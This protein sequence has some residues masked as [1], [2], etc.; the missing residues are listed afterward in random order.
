MTCSAAVYFLGIGAVYPGWPG[1]LPDRRTDQSAALD[2]VTAAG[3]PVD[4][5][6]VDV[7][8]VVASPPKRTRMSVLRFRFISLLMPAVA[9]LPSA[10]ACVWVIFLLATALFRRAVT[11][12]MTALSTACV[13]DPSICASVSP[14]RRSFSTVVRLR[15]VSLT[16]SRKSARAMCR[17]A[18][19]F[20][21]EW[22]VLAVLG[23]GVAA[24]V[25][26]LPPVTPA[27]RA[28]MM[29]TVAIPATATTAKAA[30]LIATL[31]VKK[32]PNILALLWFRLVL[33][34]AVSSF[35]PAVARVP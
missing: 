10:V 7:E 12:A 1:R 17:A 19:A 31:L 26:A 29:E 22:P 20:T 18:T 3:E 4:E 14:L 35:S 15:P 16:D 24:S 27:A 32:F 2:P 6:D 8:G 33:W 30:A 21:P 11:L 34:W 28:G 13:L 9:V 23:A 25:V 5:G